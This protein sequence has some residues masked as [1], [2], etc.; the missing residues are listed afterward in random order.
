MGELIDFIRSG[1]STRN[2]AGGP[3]LALTHE[4]MH[5]VPLLNQSTKKS[6]STVDNLFG[7]L[8]LTNLTND[9]DTT[10]LATRPRIVDTSSVKTDDQQRTYKAAVPKKSVETKDEKKEEKKEEKKPEPKDE[11]QEEKQE[12]QTKYKSTE[13]WGGDEKA[14]K[15]RHKPLEVGINEDGSGEITV[16]PAECSK[17]RARNRIRR[18]NPR[19]KRY[20]PN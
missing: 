10:K 12:Q 13:K 8:T 11:K 20:S 2:Q 4:L 9:A 19:I 15:Q 17:N 7:N 18:T 16:K 3:R 14:T 1:E 6:Q 5:E